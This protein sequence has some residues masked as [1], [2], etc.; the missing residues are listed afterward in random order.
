LCD[1]QVAGHITLRWKSEYKPFLKKKIPEIKDLIVIKKYR[2]YGVGS[3]LLDVAEGK[4]SKKSSVAGLCV[5]LDIYYGLA[6]K[7]Y[8]SRGFI[9]DGN[10]VTRLCKTIV[11]EDKVI[12]DEEFELWFTKRVR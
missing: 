12:F 4:A 6:Q 7:L 10:G 2:E 9:P 3:L 8:V 11:P 5:G 1:D